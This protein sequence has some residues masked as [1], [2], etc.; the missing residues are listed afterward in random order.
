M[1]LSDRVSESPWFLG[2]GPHLG[3]RVVTMAARMQEA[4]DPRL[5]LLERV[6]H[7]AKERAKEDPVETAFRKVVGYVLDNYGDLFMMLCDASS[8]LVRATHE[9]EKTVRE[10][11]AYEFRPRLAFSEGNRPEETASRH[12]LR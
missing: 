6:Y 5:P 4:Q 2:E 3:L 1:A 11:V 10:A 8:S 9:L 12:H 7:E